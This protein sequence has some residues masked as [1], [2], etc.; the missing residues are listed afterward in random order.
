MY[1]TSANTDT[2]S[3]TRTQRHPNAG[4]TSPSARKFALAAGS[5]EQASLAS[6]PL[7][8]TTARRPFQQI[9]HNWAP[10]QT[11]ERTHRRSVRCIAPIG[12]AAAAAAAQWLW[13]WQWWQQ[14]RRLRCCCVTLCAP[15]SMLKK[16]WRYWGILVDSDIKAWNAGAQFTIHFKNFTAKDVLNQWAKT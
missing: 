9:G 3:T 5:D 11:H 13:R 15:C 7:S 4:T 8:L 10:L 6:L 1:F 2:V 14:R 16:Q 12:A